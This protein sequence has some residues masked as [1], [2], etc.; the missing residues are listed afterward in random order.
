VNTQI[1]PEFLQAC[2]R[3]FLLELAKTVRAVVERT[4]SLTPQDKSELVSS[5][6][7]GVAAHLSGSSFGGRV[8]EEEIYPK[9]GFYKGE[10]MTLIL[11]KRMHAS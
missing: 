1:N 4:A 7:F 11:W 10:A 2:E 5:L 8:S 3:A 6:T 9:L